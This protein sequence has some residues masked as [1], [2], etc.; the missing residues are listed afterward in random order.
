[1]FWFVSRAMSLYMKSTMFATKDLD[2]LVSG[3][4]MKT[5]NNLCDVLKPFSNERPPSYQF[6]NPEREG[7]HDPVFSIIPSS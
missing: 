6:Q 3:V 7:R 4:T 1:M 5:I 2:L